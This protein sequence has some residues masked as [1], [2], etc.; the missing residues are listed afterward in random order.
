MD[1]KAELKKIMELKL[2]FKSQQQW[3][4]IEV[5]VWEENKVLSIMLTKE[6]KSLMFMLPAFCRRKKRVM[7]VVVLLITLKQ[8]MKKQYKELKIDY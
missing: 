6:N 8:N 3:E 1:L 5:I 7:M 2:E 4:N